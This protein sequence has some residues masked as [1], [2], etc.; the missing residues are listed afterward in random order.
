MT[1]GMTP[2]PT[3]QTK[4]QKLAFVKS[5]PR[6]RIVAGMVAYHGGRL[7][8]VKP[9]YRDGWLLPGGVV[10]AGESPAACCIRETQEELGL[11]L[12][13]RRLLLVDHTADPGDG[14]GDSIQFWFGTDELSPAQ[15]AQIALPDDELEAYRLVR[16]E[17]AGQFLSPRM[18]ARLKILLQH[19]GAGHTVCSEDGSAIAFDP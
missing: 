11:V 1:R 3:R 2:M 16:P 6:K 17:D 8:I 10:E 9:T 14:S 5:L 18:A 4:A 12:P 7:L 19:G 15:L 13:I